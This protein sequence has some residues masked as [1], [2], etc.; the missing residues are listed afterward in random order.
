MK[1]SICLPVF[2]RPAMLA[3]ALRTVLRQTHNNLEVVVKDGCLARPARQDEEIRAAF[4]A[5]GP[6]VRYVLSADR[7]IFPAVNEA[8]RCATGDVLYLMNSDDEL[9]DENTL[10]A[11]TAVLG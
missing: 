2:D 8:L 1:F 10:E 7:G 4:H 11:V 9:G 5:L 3:N 6:R